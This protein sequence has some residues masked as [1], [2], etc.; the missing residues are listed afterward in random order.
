MKNILIILGILIGIIGLIFLAL[1]IAAY[2]RRPKFNNKGF[3][4]L[5]KT[6]LTEL[7]EM[8][9]SE[10]Q[11]KL[12]I[13]IEYFEP[14][15]KWRQYWEKS[16]SVELYGDNENPLSDNFRYKRKDESKLATIRF[17]VN[18]DKYYIEFDNN[19]GRI[20]GWKIRPNPKSIIKVK[21]INVTS[22]KINNDP[23]S[24]AQSTFKK[25]KLKSIP[26]FDGLLGEL[27][28]IQSINQ[29]FQ[30]IDSKYLGNYT[31]SIDSKLP[32]EYLKIIEKSEGV[33]FGNFRILGVSEIYS[34]GLDDGN[35]YHL[36]EFDDGV[37]TVKEEDKSGA[38]YYCH[39]SG[40]L[41]NLGT[42]FRKIIFDKVKSTTPQHRV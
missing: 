10:I 41:D 17:K 9:D 30:P 27:N 28:N 23:N 3:T 15:R 37:I 38:I 19:D 34:T 21:A 16:M 32:N 13:Q 12:K 31:K 40:L 5:E 25:E 4:A 14:K 22:K 8:F 26:T 33:D 7:Y 1:S 18:S 11:T 42:D 20:W 6:L 39:Y 24:F 36:V 35:Y 2:R 29:I